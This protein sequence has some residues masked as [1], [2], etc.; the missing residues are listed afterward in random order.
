MGALVW[1]E[2]SLYT[3]K[4]CV[5]VRHKDLTLLP[6]Q[7]T[8]FDTNGA[9]RRFIRRAVPSLRWIYLFMLEVPAQ[10]LDFQR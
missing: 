7:L 3:P 2:P 10:T 5:K 4:S 6:L 9:P 1:I 8:T